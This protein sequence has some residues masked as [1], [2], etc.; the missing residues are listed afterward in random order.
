MFFSPVAS[1]KPVTMVGLTLIDQLVMFFFSFL[2]IPQGRFLLGVLRDVLTWHLDE[3]AYFQDSR[4]KVGGKTVIHPGLQRSFSNKP[5]S[6]DSLLDWPEFQKVLRKWHRKL[7]N[8]GVIHSYAFF[9]HV[10]VVI[11]SSALSN[12][13][14]LESSCMYTMLS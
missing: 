13:Y 12:A 1:T 10:I 3:S 8:V 9:L 6:Q 7:A 14:K 11:H 2:H 4:T 5:V